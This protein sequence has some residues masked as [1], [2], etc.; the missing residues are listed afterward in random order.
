[1]YKNTFM[2]CDVVQLHVQS[3]TIHIVQCNCIIYKLSRD[4]QI[5]Q[6][7]YTYGGMYDTQYTLGFG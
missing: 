4:L 1:M 2:M 5:M 3:P 6:K 7:R